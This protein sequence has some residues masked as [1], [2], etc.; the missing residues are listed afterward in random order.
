M[1]LFSKIAVEEVRQMGN[2]FNWRVRDKQTN[3]EIGLF[4]LRQDAYLFAR[5]YRKYYKIS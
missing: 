1:A 2:P 5:S 3:R 4:M